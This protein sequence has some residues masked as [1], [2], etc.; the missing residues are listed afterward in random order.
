MPLRG[1][2]AAT[3]DARAV[4][5]SIVATTTSRLRFASMVILRWAGRSRQ[6]LG[7]VQGDQFGDRVSA[8]P[9][10][11]QDRTAPPAHWGERSMKRI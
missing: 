8:P 9:A 2:D 5:K 10:V 1:D 11:P 6:W 7:A 4:R 3:D